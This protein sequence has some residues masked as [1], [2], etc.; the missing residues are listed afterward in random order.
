M[1]SECVIMVS[2][3]VTLRCALCSLSLDLMTN[4]CFCCYY[5]IMHS[6]AA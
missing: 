5:V 3:V 6:L 2:T 1:L 4:T